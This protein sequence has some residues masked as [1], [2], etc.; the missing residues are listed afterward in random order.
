MSLSK[1]R[2][3]AKRITRSASVPGLQVGTV[4]P[5]WIEVTATGGASNARVR[6]PNS[7][8]QHSSASSPTDQ[9]GLVLAAS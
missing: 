3:S 5:H 4:N 7:T 6:N 2:V 8:A 9:S 1:S